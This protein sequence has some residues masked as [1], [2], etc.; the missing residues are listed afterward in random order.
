[1]HQARRPPRS[2]FLVACCMEAA[3]CERKSRNIH[4]QPCSHSLFVRY[5]AV[6][7]MPA[8]LARNMCHICVRFSSAMSV[9][10]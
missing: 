7:I 9:M 8:H 2:I 6:R 4:A 10:S 5:L 1:M 3:R